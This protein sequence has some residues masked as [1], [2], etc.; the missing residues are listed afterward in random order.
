MNI[1]IIGTSDIAFRRFLP[2]LKLCKNIEF[3]GIASRRISKTEK[4]TNAFGGRGY[5]G[6]EA[7]IKDSSVDCVYIPLPP[8]LHYEWGEKALR[9]GKHVFM[10][11]PITTNLI[12]TKNLV[13]LA[14]EKSL[15]LHENYMFR[16]HEQIEFIKNIINSGE[17]GKIR[18]IRIDFGF[19][20][21]DSDNFRYN[22]FLGGGA[23]LDT[24]G[25]VILLARMFLGTTTKI[26]NIQLNYYNEDSSNNGRESEIDLYGSATLSNSDG[27]IAQVA[28]GIDNDYRCSLNIWGS[29]GTLE[30]MRILTSPSG[31]RPPAIIRKNGIEK[32]IELPPDDTFFKS[33]KH[34]ESCLSD[35]ITRIDNY[36]EIIRQAELHLSMF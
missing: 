9:H 21:K 26:S 11:K 14:N 2:A 25:Y 1:G 35:K 6:Y 20:H 29:E 5:D 10:E 33:I 22:K 18:I 32:K 15:V 28:F 24:G 23:L 30:A 34:F 31:M 17:I 7:L 4:F 36:N 12:D 27:M 16:Y 13:N 8:A 3:A 19:P